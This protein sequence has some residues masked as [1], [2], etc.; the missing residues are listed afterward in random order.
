MVSLKKMIRIKNKTFIIGGAIVAPVLII[1]LIFAIR[2]KG[3]DYEYVVVKKGTIEEKVYVTGEVVP[4]RRVDLQFEVSGRIKEISKKQGEEVVKGDILL[5]LENSDF[6]TDL[7][8][9]RAIYKKAQAELAKTAAGASLEEIQVYERAVEIA[10]VNLNQANFSLAQKK[11]EADHNLRA[12]Y[13][14]ALNTI[15]NAILKAENALNDVSLI[16]S[17]YFNINDQVGVVVKS[18]KS[19]LDASV[20]KIK[21]SSEGLSV[22]DYTAVDNALSITENELDSIYKNLEI[23]RDA[24]EKPVYRGQVPSADKSLLDTHKSNI[25]SV[26]GD[27]INTQQTIFSTR[28]DNNSNISAAE[29]A[30]EA[31]TKELR[32]A[33]AELD[34][35]KASPREEDLELAEA[36]AERALAGLRKAENNFQKTKLY[37]PCDG[38]I[39]ETG[40]EAGENIGANEKAVSVICK[41]QLQIEADIPET[42][43]GRIAA[44]NMAIVSIDAFPGKKYKGQVAEIDPAESIIQGVVYYQ[45]KIIFIPEKELIKPGMTAEVEIIT[46]SKNDVLFIPYQAI[47]E[48]AGRKTVMVLNG[49]NIEQR[50]VTTGLK[51][52]EMNVEIITGLNEGEKVVMSAKEK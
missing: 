10:E 24:C 14:D 37:S 21:D 47:K 7:Q 52:P 33:E 16:T 44:N 35:I 48:E 8:E 11:Q 30:L 13:E 27:I 2:S 20:D 6:L 9:A 46:A 36:E 41:G 32:K 28:L 50:E 22:N 51:D 25:N 38:L 15:E 43:I 49:K 23:V 17:S 34:K 19:G 40:K 26:H 3:P 4:E 42:E 1:G 12:D 29:S 18:A 39:A 45:T 31:K 5:E